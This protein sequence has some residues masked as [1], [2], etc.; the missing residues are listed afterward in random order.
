[1]ATQTS[2]VVPGGG[3]WNTDSVRATNVSPNPMLPASCKVMTAGQSTNVPATQTSP[4]FNSTGTGGGMSCVAL[5]A[6]A[7]NTRGSVTVTNNMITANSFVCVSVQNQNADATAGLA[8]IAWEGS[9][10]ARV[11]GTSF[12]I[13]YMATALMAQAWVAVFEVIN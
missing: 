13:E 5:P 1:M 7:A 9:N 11:A 3:G 6:L 4:A 8:V 12:V 10:A 2:Y